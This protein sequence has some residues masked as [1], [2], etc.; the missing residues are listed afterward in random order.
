MT[1]ICKKCNQEKDEDF[2]VTS[3]KVISDNCHLCR[4]KQKSNSV[5]NGRKKCALCDKNRRL[6]RYP[7]LK[8]LK[9]LDE[10]HRSF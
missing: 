3:R 8:D 1:K 10:H 4:R 6:K 9:N 7:D 5:E 2:F